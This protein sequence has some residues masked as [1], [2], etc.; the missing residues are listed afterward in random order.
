M[1][2]D[3][4][5]PRNKEAAA[6]QL[7]TLLTTDYDSAKLRAAPNGLGMYAKQLGWLSGQVAT[8]MNIIDKTLSNLRLSWQGESADKQKALSDEWEKVF[9]Q[10]FGTEDDPSEG[11]LNAMADGLMKAASNFA[12]AEQHVVQLFTEFHDGMVVGDHPDDK[13]AAIG[14]MASP[15]P[16]ADY[17][18]IQDAMGDG[19][20][21]DMDTDHSAVTMDYPADG[22]LSKKN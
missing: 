3:D 16:E 9:R 10:F 5:K 2:E 13:S 19:P 6:L 8:Q 4:N 18:K 17:Q 20:E 14:A 7:A 1:S 21:D 12:A 22:G 11:V 15:N